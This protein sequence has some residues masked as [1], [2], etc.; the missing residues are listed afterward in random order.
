M[1]LLGVME[2]R[3]RGL[4]QT[5]EGQ[6]PPLYPQAT[7]DAGGVGRFASQSWKLRDAGPFHRSSL[8]QQGSEHRAEA[9]PKAKGAAAV[10]SLLAHLQRS[11]QVRWGLRG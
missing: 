4:V 9:E 6:V 3:S 11:M 1:S 7:S 8:S 2:T 5:V 10:M